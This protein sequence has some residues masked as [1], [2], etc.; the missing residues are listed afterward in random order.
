[1]HYNTKEEKLRLPEYGRLVQQMAKHALE[2]EDRAQRQAYA[3]GIIRIMSHLAPQKRN[4][5]DFEHKL[6]DH[7]AFITDYELDVDYPFEIRK[8]DP[9]QRP[10]HLCYPQGKIR[11]R[12]YGRLLER[13]INKAAD[14]PEG[15]TRQE[16]VTTIANRMK[17]NLDAWKGDNVREDKV[18]TDLADYTEGRIVL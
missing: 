14:M 3:E 9:S 11:F 17:H 12:H 7:L 2:I 4:V 16:L 10:A 15:A 1:M 13:A 6:W 18:A 5:P 8:K